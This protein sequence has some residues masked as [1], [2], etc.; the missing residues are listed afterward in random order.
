MDS[1]LLNRLHNIQA[2]NYKSKVNKSFPT[3]LVYT[4]TS[5]LTTPPSLGQQRDGDR[6]RIAR[7]TPLKDL[8][9]N[10]TLPNTEVL[11]PLYPDSHAGGRE[12]R[13]GTK[14]QDSDIVCKVF[15]RNILYRRC[16]YFGSIS[17][18]CCSMERS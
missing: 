1:L 7:R 15:K 8:P 14:Q 3:N 4:L 11:L 13:E 12:L 5:T 16:F 18:H 10:G 9:P 17:N 6:E 2:L